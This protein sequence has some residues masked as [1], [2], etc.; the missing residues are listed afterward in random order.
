MAGEELDEFLQ[1]IDS[2]IIVEGKSDEDA[3]TSLGVN[4]SLIVVLNKGQSLSETIEAISDA[5][6]AIILTDMDGEGKRIRKKLLRLFQLYG[7]QEDV[8]PRELYARLR[9]S[10]VEGLKPADDV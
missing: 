2:L 10:H 4:P 1:S 7:M 9:V 8:R 3:L 5:R 6:K